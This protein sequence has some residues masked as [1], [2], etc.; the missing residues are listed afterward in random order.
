MDSAKDGHLWGWCKPHRDCFKK[1]HVRTISLW[2]PK[3]CSQQ[4]WCE[5]TSELKAR[6]RGYSRSRLLPFKCRLDI[7]RLFDP[8]KAVWP[9]HI[10]VCSSIYQV[11]GCPWK[12]NGW[13]LAFQ[14]GGYSFDSLAR[15]IR[16]HMPCSQ[17]P[18]TFS[19][20]GNKAILQQIQK[21]KN[22][23]H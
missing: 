23:T 6:S 9:G 15:E 5:F 8:G 14:C 22:C 20:K 11:W 4:A 12:S 21:F 13:D 1:P 17:K 18:K 7:H 10:S 16:F 2:T 3:S 19:K